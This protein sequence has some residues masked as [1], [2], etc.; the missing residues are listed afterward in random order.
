ML[1][2]IK[3]IIKIVYLRIIFIFV[4]K[5][6]NL[7]PEISDEEKKIIELSDGYSMTGTIRMWSFL[8]SIKHVINN[9]IDGDIVECGVWKGG[10]LIL[11]QKY[12]DLRGIKKNIYGFDTF[13]GMTEPEKIDV[14][15]RNISASDMYLLHKKK[16][17]N[18]NAWAF[19]SLDDVK[20]NLN[21]TVKKNNIILVEGRVE[22]TLLEKK[23]LPNKISVLRLDTDW[24][25]S[26]KVEL[27]NLYPRLVSGGF[28][29][30]DDYGHFKG[31][32]K[33]V[34]EYFKNDVPFLHH[35]DYTCRLIIKP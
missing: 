26:T 4:N 13:S 17:K 1:T 20:K 35:V 16:D 21:E 19:C 15:Y 7:P 6:K 12:L 2:F 28:L 3:K 18:Q 32:K 30:I 24:Y 5:S 31:C 8:Q 11:A 25:S 14:D 9:K 29:I 22:K 34:D 23:N 33:A 27:E 10:N